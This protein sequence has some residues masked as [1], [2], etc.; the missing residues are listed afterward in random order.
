MSTNLI[1]IGRVL[2][3]TTLSRSALYQVMREDRTFP[4]PVRLCGRRTLAFSEAEVDR[5]ISDQLAQREST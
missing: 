1:K 4:R 3:K 2:E 5:W